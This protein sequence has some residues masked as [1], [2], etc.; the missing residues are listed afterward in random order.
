MAA[1]RKVKPGQKI[2]K[3]L[4]ASTWNA[5][6]DALGWIENFKRGDKNQERES[7]DGIVQAKNES[8]QDFSQFD[9]AALRTILF[10]PTDNLPEFKN[11]YAFRTAIYSDDDKF[12]WG[13]TQQPTPNGAIGPVCVSGPTIA[14]INVSNEAHNY[15][16]PTEGVKSQLESSDSGAK[17]L[18]K[19]PGTGE[20]K[21]AVILLPDGDGDAIQLY[22][23]T[24]YKDRSYPAYA[25]K[26]PAIIE[27]FSGVD[28]CDK[29][30]NNPAAQAEIEDILGESMPDGWN[31]QYVWFD[32]DVYPFARGPMDAGDGG[33]SAAGGAIGFAWFDSSFPLDDDEET[34]GKRWRVLVCDQRAMFFQTQA[35]F[36]FPYADDVGSIGSNLDGDN[37][38]DNGTYGDEYFLLGTPIP[39]GQWP[40]SQREHSDYWDEYPEETSPNHNSIVSNPLRYCGAVGDKG[41]ITYKPESNN[42]VLVSTQVRNVTALGEL[43]FA[44]CAIKAKNKRFRAYSRVD[45]GEP[46]A[47]FETALQLYTGTYLAGG[48]QY[49]IKGL[50]TEENP[51]GT[52]Q[53]DETDY[54]ELEAD[55]RTACF[56]FEEQSETQN[57]VGTNAKQTL[58]KGVKEVVVGTDVTFSTYL[59][60]QPCDPIDTED[61]VIEGTTECPE[62]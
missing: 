6:V 13:I 56:L 40:F 23:F 15:A 57:F 52:P 8:Y 10:S 54:C 49:T 9:V 22:K 20:N 12:K 55:L 17:V 1:N 42:W 46:T 27:N 59:I 32:D 61:V 30:E 19:E 34:C 62:P 48:M 36:H 39:L 31:A 29:P 5:M 53:G 14:R 44:D 18:W 24:L 35:K 51:S 41:I 3:S 2:H 43:Q 38:G 16:K 4:S 58:V 50:V 60:F 11:N 37:P 45:G 25:E 47:E 7:R 26:L 21:L 28:S 33:E